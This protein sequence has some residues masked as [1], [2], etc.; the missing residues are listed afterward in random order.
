MQQNKIEIKAGAAQVV[1]SRQDRPIAL[2]PTY[3]D[4][5]V[6]GSLVFLPL[7][8]SMCSNVLISLALAKVGFCCLHQRTL[9][10]TGN[11]PR[12][13][14]PDFLNLN[15]IFLKNNHFTLVLA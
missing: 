2:L 14:F 1:V 5:L 13:C 10:C 6:P 12:R 3:L 11:T 7:I 15:Y 9:M 8:H 4:P